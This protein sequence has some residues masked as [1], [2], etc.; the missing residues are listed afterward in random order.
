M[1]RGMGLSNRVCRG[2]VL[3]AGEGQARAIVEAAAQSV[4][5]LK[6]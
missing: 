1:D 6:R 2:E 3:S 4:V 5:A